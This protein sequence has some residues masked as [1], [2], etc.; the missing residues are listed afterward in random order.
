MKKLIEV[1]EDLKKPENL[2]KGMTFDEFCD[3][4]KLGTKKDLQ[5]AL[6]EFEK[7][8]LSEHCKIIKYYIEQQ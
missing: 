2:V 3:W 6:V 8:T 7:S 1:Y 5:M 4:C